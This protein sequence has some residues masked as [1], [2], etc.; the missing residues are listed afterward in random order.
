MASVHVVDHPLIQHK[1]SI[2]RQKDTGPKEFRE[3]TDEIALLMAYEVTRDMPLEE[4]EIETP[5][6]KTRTYMIKGKKIGVVPILRA[7][8]GMVGGILQLIP[9]AKVGHVG[10]YRDPATLSPSNTIANSRRT[11]QKGI[12]SSSIRCSQLG[13]APRRPLGF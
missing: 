7:G 8:L 5:L 2:L 11:P 13:E 3:L 4:V 1:L 12:S 10:V 6:V 9:A